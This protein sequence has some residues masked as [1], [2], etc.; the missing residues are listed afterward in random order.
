MGDKDSNSANAGN[1]N[2]VLKAVRE[3]LIAIKEEVR[4]D[5]SGP[6]VASFGF[7]IALVWRDAI[8][9]AFGEYLL[10]AGLTE[11]AYIYQFISAIIV[12]IAVIIIMVTITKISRARR[13]ERI[14]ET[15]EK[16]TEKKIIE[17]KK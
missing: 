14:E 7:I 3:E 8:Q 9:S 17:N 13:V 11:K 12:T 6:V 1:S 2:K 16:R 15:I 10:R 5:V 4:N